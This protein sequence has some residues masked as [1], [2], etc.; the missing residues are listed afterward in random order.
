VASGLPRLRCDAARV[1]QLL[2]NLIVN[3]VKYNEAAERMVEV[4]CVPGA[5]GDAPVFYVRDNGIGIRPQHCESIFRMFRRLHHRDQYGGGT[6]VGLTLAKRI[7][8]RHGGRIWVESVLGEGS[9]FYFTLSPARGQ[10]YEMAGE[11]A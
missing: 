6:G 1:G 5:D 11:E 9:T 8:E 4:G 10:F 2:S 7:V 3:A